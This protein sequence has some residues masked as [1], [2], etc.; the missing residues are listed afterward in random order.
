MLHPNTKRTLISLAVASACGLIAMSAHAQTAST[1]PKTEGRVADK[2]KDKDYIPEIK[3]T[4][5][6]YS[7]SLLKTPIAVT[8]FSQDNLARLGVTSA[9]DLANEIPNV[10][11]QQTGDSAVQITIRGITS[12]NTTEIGDPAVG[13]HV[14]GLYSP[15]P[16]GA[17]ALMFD[18]EQ[19]EVLRGPQGTLFGRNSTGGSVNVISAKPDFTGNYGKAEVDFGNYNKRQVNLIQNITVNDKLA[20]RAA[21]TKVTRDGYANQMQDKREANDPAHGWIPDGI[22]DID[23]RWNVPVSKKDFY[24]NQ[25]SYAARLAAK[26]KVNPALTLNAAFEIFQDNSAG[27]TSFADCEQRAGTRYAC[28]GGQ[29]DLLINVPG[30]TD[31]SIKSLRA[32]A[33]WAVNN[34]TTLDYNFMIADQ[35]RFQIYDADKGLTAALPFQVSADY[36]NRPDANNWGT[37]P[38][39]DRYQATWDSKYVSTVHELQLK[40]QYE[41]LQYVAGLFWMHEKNQ[42]DYEVVDFFRKPYALASGAFYA[43]PNRQ[44]DAK[45]IFAQADWKF[46]PTWT[47]TAGARFSRDSKTDKDGLNLGGW[48]GEKAFYNGT[49]DPGTPNTPGYRIPQGNDLGPTVGGSAA[50]YHLYGAPSP[51]DHS[52]SW[53]KITW[54]LGLQKQMTDNQMAYTALSTGYKAGGF[55]DKVDSC[56]GNI[57]LDGKPGVPTFLP[58]KPELVTN[59]EFGYKGKFL[60]NRLSLSAVAFMMRYKDQQLT[61]TYFVTKFQPPG[62]VP[63]ASDQPKCDV[64]ET[65]R[66]INVGNTRIS[67]LEVEWDYKPWKGGK[68]GGSFANLNTSIRDYGSYSD[69][70]LCDERVEFNQTRCPAPY[71]GAGPDNGKRLYDVTGNHLPNAPKFTWSLNFSQAL[72]M[73]NGWK[74]TPYV[75]MNW[76]DKV[77]FDVRNDEFAHIG[78]YQKSY[79]TADGS[80]RLDSPD[81][82]FHIEAYVRNMTD[83]RAKNWG[84]SG[85][86]GQMIASFIEPRMYGVRAGFSY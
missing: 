33:S 83:E 47:A 10:N 86:G 30:R 80:L 43:Q 21:F 8:A 68:V 64:Y 74:F 37:W 13:F 23:Q 54:R 78:R 81:N 1:A 60:D 9:K 71:A 3:V 73:E 49:Y 36:P 11:I 67:G 40:Q 16:Q 38:L 82:R 25:D 5:T 70:Y 45:A 29:W 59:L 27:G 51:N 39:D 57:C 35:R 56:G 41:T 6:R 63:C 61:G 7:T 72:A 12:S 55:G 62:G 79:M 84:G 65:W 77:Y 24:T 2:D 34:H 69:D 20:L 42:I 58:Y 19:V 46:M 50:A 76:R 48:W 52:D 22:P 32:G 18:V 17:Q 31:M 4:A 66:T 85:L 75:K 28:T 44:V 14:D 53:K 26:L 15:R